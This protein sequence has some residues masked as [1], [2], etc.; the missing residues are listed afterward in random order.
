MLACDNSLLRYIS[1]LMFNESVDHM[2][3]RL[4]TFFRNS[5]RER[6]VKELQRQLIVE[7]TSGKYGLRVFLL[8]LVCEA[9]HPSL[10]MALQ[11]G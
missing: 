8:S 4:L 6:S 7:D 3:V 9:L 5:F 2:L 11:L 10:K 1:V